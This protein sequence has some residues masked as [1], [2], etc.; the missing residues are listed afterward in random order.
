MKQQREKRLN[1]PEVHSSL[2]CN[3]TVYFEREKV[4]RDSFYKQKMNCLSRKEILNDLNK[5]LNH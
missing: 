4:S 1:F 5:K 3:Y 2:P